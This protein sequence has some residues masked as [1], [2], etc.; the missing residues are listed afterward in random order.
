MSATGVTVDKVELRREGKK[1]SQQ[2]GV[3]GSDLNG[4]HRCRPRVN[5]E[6]AAFPAGNG[7]FDAALLEFGGKKK[8]LALAPAPRFFIVEMENSQM[9]RCTI[10]KAGKVLNDFWFGCVI[11]QRYT[12]RKC[13]HRCLCPWP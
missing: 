12:G 7:V 4:R 11:V 3:A 13:R 2:S 8:R 5:F 1:V 6:R 9:L 10:S